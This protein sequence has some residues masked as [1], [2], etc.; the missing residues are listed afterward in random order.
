MEKIQQLIFATMNTQTDGDVRH[1]CWYIMRRTTV[2]L[3]KF[4][5]LNKKREAAL[6]QGCLAISKS[7][8]KNIACF[9][10]SLYFMK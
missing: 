4:I 8:I 7:L 9:V 5:T 1:A 2:R 10:K 6:S 3:Y